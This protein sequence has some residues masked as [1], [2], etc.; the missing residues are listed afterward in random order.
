MASPFTSTTASALPR[1]VPV[2]RADATQSPRASVSS[3]FA[4]PSLT[5]GG[6][7]S[8]GRSAQATSN[9]ASTGAKRM[10]PELRN[11]HAR[12]DTV[13]PLAC[14]PRGWPR[15]WPVAGFPDPAHEPDLL[16]WRE[17]HVHAQAE[18]E[19]GVAGVGDEEHLEDAGV[20]A[21]ARVVGDD[22]LAAELVG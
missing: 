19:E 9:E 2:L 12:R 18:G 1:V 7:S 14:R 3:Y 16:R 20:D 6:A 21:G 11:R 4:P 17:V 5:S 8:S 22:L 10:G 15:G 13:I